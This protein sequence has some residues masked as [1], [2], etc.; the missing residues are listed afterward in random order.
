MSNSIRRFPRM[1]DTWYMH[2][3]QQETDVFL[4]SAD[5]ISILAQVG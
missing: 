3:V 5:G 1:G 4:T 2:P